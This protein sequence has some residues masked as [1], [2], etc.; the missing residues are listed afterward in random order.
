M[1]G[2]HERVGRGHRIGVVYAT[3][4]ACEGDE[5]G[6]LAQAVLQIGP[7]LPCPRLEPPGGLSIISFSS[8][9][10]RAR[11]VVMASPKS[12]GKDVPCVET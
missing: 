1:V 12:N 2:R 8:G 9:I 4:L 11:S 10:P 7:N 6:A 5:A 3:V